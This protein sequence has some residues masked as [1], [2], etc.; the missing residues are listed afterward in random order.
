MGTSRN[1]RAELHH[2]PSWIYC[3][4][5]QQVDAVN[6]QKLLRNHQAIWCPPPGFRPWPQNHP[7]A[8]EVLWLIWR[9]NPGAHTIFLLGRGK[10]LAAPK[11]NYGTTVL[12][13]GPDHP[14]L[15]EAAMQL[16]YGG[17]TAMSFLRLENICLPIDG[18]P[19][20]QNLIGI[21]NRFNVANADQLAVLQQTL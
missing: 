18:V 10:I 11:Q 8:G 4:T 5:A 1:K 17:G 9:E 15:R 19:P 7:K 12:W 21:Q 20:I 13:T 2:M 6:T 3:G 16:G 14:I